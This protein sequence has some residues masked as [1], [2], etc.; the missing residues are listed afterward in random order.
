MTTLAE[1]NIRVFIAVNPGDEVRAELLR[2]QGRLTR[3]L[4]GTPFRIKWVAQ[5][6]M[7]LTLFFLGKQS[8]AS[9]ETVFK[10]LEKTVQNFPRFGMALADA[11]YFGRPRAPRV[12]WIGLD[13]PPPLFDLQAQLAAVLG[14]EENKPFCPH[15]TLGR[16]KA[17]RGMEVFQWLRKA[18]VKPV[19]FEVSSVELI[20]SELTPV[21]A[22]YTVLGSA[23]LAE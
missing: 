12:L 6:A 4:A 15:L 7:H 23:P 1:E 18:Q 2:Q 21:G 20:K 5:E 17:G 16:V 14:I 8:V 10:T 22:R 9:A 3:E 11:G 13:A 19:S